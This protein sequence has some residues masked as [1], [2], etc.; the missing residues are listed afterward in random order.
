MRPPPC[1]AGASTC[2]LCIAGTAVGECSNSVDLCTNL[3]CRSSSPCRSASAAAKTGQRYGRHGCVLAVSRRVVCLRRVES[4]VAL[5]GLVASALRQNLFFSLAQ[6]HN[7]VLWSRGQVL[8][9]RV[10]I[11]SSKERNADKA[12]RR[13]RHTSLTI[14]FSSLLMSVKRIG[15]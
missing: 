11:A 14:N 9:Q 4:L 12:T 5:S 8:R 2:P 10:Q 1:G 13:E 3:A 15:W 6:I 7:S